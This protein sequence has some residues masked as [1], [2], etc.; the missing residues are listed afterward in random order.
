MGIRYD[1]TVC[2]LSPLAR[3]TL[4]RISLPRP[5]VRFIPAGAGNTW[6]LTFSAR[7]SAVYPRWRGEHALYRLFHQQLAG[8]SPLARGTR[9]GVDLVVIGGRFIPA[10][11]GNT[12][13]TVPGAPGDAVYPRWRGEHFAITFY[14]PSAAGLS[15]L[16]RGTRPFPLRQIGAKRF[17]PA[18]AGNTSPGIDAS[19]PQ[20]VYPRWRGEHSSDYIGIKTLIGLSPLARGTRE[21]LRPGERV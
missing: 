16:A 18:G 4:P 21:R 3:G 12:I 7:P 1:N 10:G 15:P 13:Y 2:G 19:R 17:I 8:L 5:S 20:P 14:R 9:V 11:A 6:R